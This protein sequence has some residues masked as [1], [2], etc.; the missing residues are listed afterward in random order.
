MPR[1]IPTRRS[2]QRAGSPTRGVAAGAKV[3]LHVGCGPPDP[4]KVHER[5]RGPGWHELR[6]DIDPEVEPDILGTIVDMRGVESASVD[7]VYSSHN[8]EHVR[9]HE[10]PVVLAEFF[11]VLRPGGELLVTMPDLQTVAKFVASGHLE[12]PCYE[13][14]MGPVTPLDILYGFGPSIARGND[15]MAHR[16]GYT[17]RTLTHRLRETGFVSID[18][19]RGADKALWGSAR[20]PG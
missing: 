20:R 10:A 5:F 17:A 15:F 9:A 7:A 12:E 2:R 14:R 3:V 18:V 13:S 19:K 8:L 6:F 16:T 1:L 11:R 4:A